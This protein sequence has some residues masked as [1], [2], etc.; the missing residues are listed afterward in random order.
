MLFYDIVFNPKKDGLYGDARMMSPRQI[1]RYFH[2]KCQ[3][4]S[5]DGKSHLKP[6]YTKLNTIVICPTG[7]GKS[8]L[9]KSNFLQKT[10]QY[11]HS[12][13]VIDPASD[14][15]RDTHKWLESQGFNVKVVN[16]DDASKSLKINVL[17]VASQTP[18]GIEDLASL[19][20]LIQYDGSKKGD[21][22]WSDSAEIILTLLMRA[23]VSPTQNEYPKNLHTVY[24]LLNWF[25]ASP[26][27]LDR[28]ILTHLKN[29]QRLKE[30]YKSLVA[31]SSDNSKML[32]SIVSTAKSAIA[33]LVNNETI[34]EIISDDTFEIETL[35]QKPQAIFIQ[36]R[37]DRLS[38]NGVKAMLSIINKFLMAQCMELPKQG[39]K[40]L[41]VHAYIDEAGAFYLQS[42]DSYVVTMRKRAVSIMLFFQ[43]LEQLDMYGV[44]QKKVIVNNCLNKLIFPSVSTETA[45]WASA[46]LGNQ[47]KELGENRP[48]GVPLLSAQQICE[49]PKHSFLY[50][51]K[52]KA[53][54]L[55]SKP[56]YKQIKLK[57]RS[58]L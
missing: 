45:L 22:F 9:I 31:N 12:F 50:I 23:V 56:W 36:V 51:H 18:N 32:L 48:V 35:R 6:E 10:N 24:M 16:L 55:K 57:R 20:L 3:G 41:K 15:Y 25:G 14:I 30:E 27:K 26:E 40:Q 29:N 34:G 58:K 54:I 7:G 53:K 47:T 28:F 33:K 44:S 19:L 46:L 11:L 43:S 38:N 37:E 17:L 21:P 39:E 4:I 49:L 1:R 52:N 5:F 2:R 42:L 13:W 8:S